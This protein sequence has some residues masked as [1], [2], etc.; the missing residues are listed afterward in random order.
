MNIILGIFFYIENYFI[1]HAVYKKHLDNTKFVI[2][3]N[4]LAAIPVIILLIQNAKEI[5][6]INKE[7]YVD[8]SDFF[9]MLFKGLIQS[10]PILCSCVIIYAVFD[11]VKDIYIKFGFIC[12][13]LS[14]FAAIFIICALINIL[15][16]LHII[17]FFK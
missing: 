4:I 16:S 5:S 17:I 11:I 14:I 10:P 1:M 6:E 7:R 8:I 13:S 3:I 12:G 9:S 15:Q 2:L